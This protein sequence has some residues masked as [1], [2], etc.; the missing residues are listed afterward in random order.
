MLRAKG[1][2]PSIGETTQRLAAMLHPAI[3]Y[4]LE[5]AMGEQ[6]FSGRKLKTL[7]KLPSESPALNHFLSKMPGWRLYRTYKKLTDARKAVWQR[8]LDFMSGVK[9][10]TYDALKWEAIDTDRALR[11]F[12]QEHPDVREMRRFY[13]PAAARAE[14][15]PEAIRAELLSRKM[16]QRIR[17]LSASMERG[18]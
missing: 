8:G 16:Q 5:R 3:Q 10:S 2:L 7:K 17:E 1:G 6:L 14:A 13:I 11:E 4:P 9:F 18:E 12:L 15:D